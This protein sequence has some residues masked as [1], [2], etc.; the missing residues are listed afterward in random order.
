MSYQLQ[1]DECLSDGFKRIAEEQVRDA[2]RHLQ[3]QDNLHTG[4]YE[5]RKSLKKAR[6]VLRLL[7]PQLGPLAVEE[8]HRLRDVARRFG[9]IRDADVSLEVLESFADKYKRKST[10][11]PHRKALTERH[12]TLQ[13][14]PDWQTIL[15]ESL[16]ALTG[17]CKRIPDW[18]LHDV[19]KG[20]LNLQ[21][22]KTH[23][24]GRHAFHRARQTRAAEDFHELR[25]CSKRELN[26][27]RLFEEFK[28]DLGALKQLS[29][30]L[31]DHHNLAVLVSTLENTSGRF[32]MMA[33]RQLRL[34]ESQAIELASGFYDTRMPFYILSNAA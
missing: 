3:S 20:S 19:T 25:K 23:K 34:H 22:K 31:G 21:L 17:T 13:R 7:A 29:S 14:L 11:D 6:A 28:H 8:S 18:H 5:A 4:I 2:I 26:Q 9:D 10:L 15:A 16:D 32:R 30:V 27:L 24:E 1:K 33:K 12:S